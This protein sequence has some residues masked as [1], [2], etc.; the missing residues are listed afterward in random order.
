MTSQQASNAAQCKMGS[1]M[2]EIII[3]TLLSA[4][5]IPDSVLRA[6]IIFFPV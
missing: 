1:R 6:Y 3:V 2:I 4:Y 5:P